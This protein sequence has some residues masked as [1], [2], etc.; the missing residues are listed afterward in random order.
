LRQI[1]W[2]RLVKL[3]QRHLRARKR[4]TAREELSLPALPD[5]S[6]LQLAGRLIDSGTG[7]GERVVR[8]ELRGRVRAAL[9]RVGE[10]EREL[11]VMRYLEGLSLK[12]IAAALGITVGAVKMRHVRAL[13]ALQKLLAGEFGKGTA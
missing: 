11:L 5:D 6:V 9:A 7:P 4:S 13:E 12:E 10:R 8:N 3:H 2:E 1:A